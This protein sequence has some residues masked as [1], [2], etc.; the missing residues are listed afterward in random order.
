MTYLRVLDEHIL[1]CVL[2]SWSGGVTPLDYLDTT[3]DNYHTIGINVDILPIQTIS[4]TACLQ[5]AY[6]LKKSS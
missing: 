1:P 5:Y 2:L 3:I 6:L 4:S